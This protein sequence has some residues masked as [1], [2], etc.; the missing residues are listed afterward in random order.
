MDFLGNVTNAGTDLVRTLKII[1]LATYHTNKVQDSCT[2][3]KS[4]H[5]FTYKLITECLK[6]VDAFE[7][8]G[9][10]LSS[11]IQQLAAVKKI[12]S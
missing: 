8:Q 7:P 6:I 12:N 11:I 4:V 9:N 3:F 2:I 1:F 10:K 5:I